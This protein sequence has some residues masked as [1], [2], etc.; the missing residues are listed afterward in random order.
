MAYGTDLKSGFRGENNL[1]SE[2]SQWIRVARTW[3]K[4]VW[5]THEWAGAPS[6]VASWHFGKAH[7]RS[8]PIPHLSGH[9]VDTVSVEIDAI[10]GLGR[11]TQTVIDRIQLHLRRRG[12]RSGARVAPDCWPDVYSLDDAAAPYPYL[13]FRQL[14]D[15]WVG[16][17]TNVRERI[18][19]GVIA[20]LTT[21]PAAPLFEV[22]ERLKSLNDTSLQGAALP[23][24]IMKGV[25]APFRESARAMVEKTAGPELDALSLGGPIRDAASQTFAL[26]A[27]GFALRVRTPVLE[28]LF[29]EQDLTPKEYRDRV[30]GLIDCCVLQERPGRQ[31]VLGWMGPRRVAK[32]DEQVGPFAVF[33]STMHFRTCIS[34][35]SESLR[36]ANSLEPNAPSVARAPCS[37]LRI[38][39]DARCHEVVLPAGMSDSVWLDTKRRAEGA[40]RRTLLNRKGISGRQPD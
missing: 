32:N 22:C 18:D 11:A 4:T 19:L 39:K 34:L 13:A 7:S 27:E 14:V 1:T 9:T 8:S 3:W 35:F 28:K 17:E 23:D 25:V 10:D 21:S 20:M 37:A 2:Q 24:A 29:L 40:R 30:A 6:S 26:F 36:P 12:I 31:G 38:F 33:Q 15:F 5:G 16:R